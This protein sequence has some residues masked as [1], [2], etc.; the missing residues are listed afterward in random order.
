MTTVHW[1]LSLVGSHVTFTIESGSGLVAGEPKSSMRI[2][3][4]S[5]LCLV[6]AALLVGTGQRQGGLEAGS[7]CFH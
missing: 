2:R 4:I 1:A 6:L 7:M 5:S 3:N